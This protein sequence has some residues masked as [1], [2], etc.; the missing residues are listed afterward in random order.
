MIV[1]LM[2]SNQSSFQGLNGNLPMPLLMALLQKNKKG[3]SKHP[4]AQLMQQGM[5]PGLLGQHP[6]ANNHPLLGKI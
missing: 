6:V 1:P 4:M 5:G 3:L 2:L